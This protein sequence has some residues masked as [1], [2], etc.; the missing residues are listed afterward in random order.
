M[1]YFGEPLPSFWPKAIVSSNLCP[2]R[3]YYEM[4]KL[5]RPL[6]SLFQ[7]QKGGNCMQIWISND[8]PQEFK[9]CEVSWN[10]VAGDKNLTTQ[11]LAF[12]RQPSS[13]MGPE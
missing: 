8:L 12:H 10:I 11:Q 1:F 7:I 9:N 2:K 6:V 5:N 3:A 4:A 13:L